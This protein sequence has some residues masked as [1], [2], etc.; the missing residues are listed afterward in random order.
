[1]VRP[2]SHRSISSGVGRW[3]MWKHHETACFLNFWGLTTVYKNALNNGS[4]LSMFYHFVL[5]T[6]PYAKTIGVFD[7]DILCPVWLVG[8][9]Y[10]V[11]NLL[12][13]THLERDSLQEGLEYEEF[14]KQS[15]ALFCYDNDLSASAYR[16]ACNSAL[17][18]SSHC[19]KDVML[20]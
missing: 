14:T 13:G 11:Y 3:S 8:Q 12:R 6:T 1:M 10:R 2:P 15:T 7:I 9:I 20:V 16:Q 5:C 18:L 17:S 4:R 19:A